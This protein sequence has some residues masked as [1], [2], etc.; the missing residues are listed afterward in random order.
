MTL[1]LMM[2]Q[3]VL[4][5]ASGRPVQ[6]AQGDVAQVPLDEFVTQVIDRLEADLS[7]TKALIP[8]VKFW[9][10]VRNKMPADLALDKD[11]RMIVRRAIDEA[12]ADLKAVGSRGD[13]T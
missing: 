13:L 12:L 2:T 8:A 3:I 5:W 11:V 10:R 6:M 4:T 7:D 1:K 9:D